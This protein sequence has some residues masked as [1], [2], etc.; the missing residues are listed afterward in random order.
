[1]K[2]DNKYFPLNSA[3]PVNGYLQSQEAEE[4]LQEQLNSAKRSN[5]E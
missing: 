4:G 2:E 1:M 3:V 5:D